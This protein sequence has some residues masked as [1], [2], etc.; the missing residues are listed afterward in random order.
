ME[1]SKA[2]EIE[3]YYLDLHFKKINNNLVFIDLRKV[4]YT[5]SSD[6]SASLIFHSDL[7]L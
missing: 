3:F 2:K 7:G 6:K 4:Y 5:Q 1:L